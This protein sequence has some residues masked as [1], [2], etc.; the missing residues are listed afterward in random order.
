MLKVENTEEKR[1]TRTHGI[2][3]NMGDTSSAGG[4]TGDTRERHLT[5]Q[6]PW[7]R[8]TWDQS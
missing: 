4:S 6:G 3:G 7:G 1:P 5:L 2:E 8:G